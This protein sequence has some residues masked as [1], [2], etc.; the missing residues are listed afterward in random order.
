MIWD[1]GM[2]HNQEMLQKDSENYASHIKI[3]L[4][5]DTEAYSVL[6]SITHNISLSDSH[7]RNSTKNKFFSFNHCF[8]IY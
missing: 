8:K 3:I 4:I 5:F 1:V 2:F 6:F 7:R